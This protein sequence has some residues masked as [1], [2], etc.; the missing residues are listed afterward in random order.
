MIRT[1]R[2]SERPADSHRE[3]GNQMATQVLD[4]AAVQQLDASTK[5]DVLMPGKAGY[6]EARACR[7]A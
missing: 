1:S 6:D 7:R 5:G 3:R 4:D 2:L